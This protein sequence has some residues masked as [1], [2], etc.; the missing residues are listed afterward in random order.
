[1]TYDNLMDTVDRY[2]ASQSLETCRSY[3]WMLRRLFNWLIE[4]QID[5]VSLSPELIEIYLDE[6]ESWGTNSRRQAICAARSFYRWWKGNSHPVLQTRLPKS[7][8][9]PQ[10][11][12]TPKQTI[13][14]LASIDQGSDIGKRDL[15]MVTLMLDTGLRESEVARLETRHVNLDERK[16][17]VLVKGGCWGRA[18]FSE[19]TVNH[20]RDWL[21]VK[22]SLK[23]PPSPSLF[24]ALQTGNPLTGPGIRERFEAL[25]RQSGVTVSPHDLRRTFA[26]LTTK[27]GAPTRVAMAAGRWNNL[28]VFQRYTQAIEPED[29]DPWF[30]TNY[31]ANMTL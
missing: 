19:I 1:M 18:V 4:H 28:A 5:P 15:A 25:S 21:R 13:R 9:C 6:N 31:L 7:N 24:V 14:L 11:T 27:A 8:P 2:L 12:L 29:I 23:F 3:A 30:P 20:L 17:T 22:D 16:L 26:T 10:R